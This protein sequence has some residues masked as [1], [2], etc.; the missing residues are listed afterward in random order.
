[1]SSSV[2]IDGESRKLLNINGLDG[3]TFEVAVSS[4]SRILRYILPII[5]F[6]ITMVGKVVSTE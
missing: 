2:D 4:P 1:M 3:S 6:A 5:K